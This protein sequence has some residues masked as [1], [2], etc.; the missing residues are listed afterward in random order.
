MVI[1][2]ARRQTLDFGLEA[3]AAI[4]A[5]GS[6][7]GAGFDDACELGGIGLYE[8]DGRRKQ[9]GVIGVNV[10]AVAGLG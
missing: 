1:G 10:T 3:V 2:R 5:N 8:S 4:V 9:H 6:G 7:V